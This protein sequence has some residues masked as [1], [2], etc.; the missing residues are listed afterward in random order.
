[1]MVLAGAPSFLMASVAPL[2]MRWFLVGGALVIAG[3]GGMKKPPG[4]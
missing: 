1:M 3:D 4:G 2:F